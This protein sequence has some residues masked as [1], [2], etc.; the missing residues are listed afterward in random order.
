MSTPAVFIERAQKVPFWVWLLVGLVVALLGVVGV[1]EL[2]KSIG[3]GG[4]VVLTGAGLKAT[5]KTGRRRHQEHRQRA[6]ERAE[7]MEEIRR[8]QAEQAE[9]KGGSLADELNRRH[10]Q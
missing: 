3:A 10:H 7:E 1:I 9:G 5:K 8:K 6:E 4:T 2:G